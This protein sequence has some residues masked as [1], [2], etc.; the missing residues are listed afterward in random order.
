MVLVFEEVRRVLR[1]DGTLWL[2]LGDTYATGA[3]KVG[4]RP[5]GGEQ[6]DR[7]A[8]MPLSPR[9]DVY[10][11]G[12]RGERLA[13]GSKDQA[14]VLRKKTRAT[15]DGSHAGINIA[16]AA[17]GPMT[18]PNRLA[19]PGLKPKDLIGIPWM[20]A[21]ALRRAGWW[22]R[23]EN[24]W[25]K[26]NPMPESTTD[27]CTV[28]HETVFLL[29]KSERYFYD[30]AAVA[31]E[32]IYQPG[33]THDDVKQGGFADKGIIPMP[34]QAQRA[35]RAIRET[36]NKRSVW[37]LPTTPFPG[38]HFATF[39]PALVEPCVKAGTSEHG[40][41]RRCAAP[42][43]R[44]ARKIFSPQPDVSA[45]KVAR[46]AD[47][48]DETS[49]WD[50]V[51]RGTV[52]TETLGWYPTCKCDALP[53]LPPYPKKAKG[54][55]DDDVMREASERIHR[56]ACEV[57]DD[58]RSSLCRAASGIPVKRAVVIDP[59]GG[60]GTTAL[61]A[62]RLQ[63]DGVIIEMNPGYAEMARKRIDADAG[64]FGSAAE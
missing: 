35:F 60:A 9:E 22:L 48:M 19:L 11:R 51:P 2:N 4:D 55:A 14:A 63:R 46:R 41:C 25:A 27:R 61:V 28:A 42:W 16:M 18:Q 40:A 6:G 5:G 12:Y 26:P 45:D 1:R 53:S 43:A 31:E 24:I 49:N 64:M 39:P 36:R 3:G 38:A 54:G 58:K 10:H 13:N 52:A 59:F 8:G 57:I 44:V 30:A 20:C 32:A 34:G 29:A 47:E 23:G 37:T 7:W 21:F 56:E 15:R 50:D 33:G 17:R 62:D